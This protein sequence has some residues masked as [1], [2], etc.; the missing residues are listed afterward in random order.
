MSKGYGVVIERDPWLDDAKREIGELK[1]QIEA[2]TPDYE[3]GG[4]VRRMPE[5]WRYSPGTRSVVLLFDKSRPDETGKWEVHHV[6][7][8]S[9]K[10]APEAGLR[11]AL[12]E[13]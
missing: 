5:L 12:G 2:M 4:L 1:A 3:L 10:D 7:G 8:W 11:E 6:G 13:E 9:I